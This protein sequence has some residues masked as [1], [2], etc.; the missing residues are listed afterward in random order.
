MSVE[1]YPLC[2]PSGWTRENCVEES[3]FATSGTKAH[4][5][6]MGE[7]SRMG[8]TAVIVSTNVPLRQ[9]GMIRMDREPVDSGV[10]V[11]FTRKEKQ[12][13]FACDRFD[14]L[15]DNMLSI[16]KTIEALR[17]IE[18]WGAS[19]MMERAFSGFKQLAA[20]NGEAP[21]WVVLGVEEKATLTKIHE[22]YYRGCKEAHPDVDGGD[23]ELMKRLNVAIQQARNARAK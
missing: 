13:V 20:E 22:A 23:E 21:W 6:L 8:G 7:V 19:D 11:Y 14:L 9:D 10:A 4:K 16:A 18:R 17:G 15:R 5:M 1:A 3:K 2:W 12:V